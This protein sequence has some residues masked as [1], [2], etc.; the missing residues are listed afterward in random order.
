M[1]FQGSSSKWLTFTFGK[2]H[3]SQNY[4]KGLF[5]EVMP[6]ANNVV[7]ARSYIIF[8]TSFWFAESFS[9]TVSVKT[10]GIDH[11]AV[12]A[13]SKKSMIFFEIFTKFKKSNFQVVWEVYHY[14]AFHLHVELD[15]TTFRLI[16]NFYKVLNGMF[17]EFIYLINQFDHLHKSALVDMAAITKSFLIK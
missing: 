10:T 11:I 2:R 9:F 15:I 12:Y 3:F 4:I 17:V 8:A 13:D 16:C 7:R 14:H 1:S 6:S 5:V